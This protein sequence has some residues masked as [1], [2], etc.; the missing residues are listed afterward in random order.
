MTED[1]IKETNENGILYD[2]VITCDRLVK[3]DLSPVST[4]QAYK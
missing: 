3:T 1:K 2:T 4:T